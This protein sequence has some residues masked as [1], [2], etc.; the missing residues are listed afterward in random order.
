[1][2]CELCIPKQL[3]L[4]EMVENRLKERALSKDDAIIGLAFLKCQLAV[5]QSIEHPQSLIEVALPEVPTV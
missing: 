4:I 1:M 5:Q 3:A 2:L